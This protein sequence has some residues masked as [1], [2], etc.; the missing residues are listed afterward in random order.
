MFQYYVAIS[1]SDVS[2]S[3]IRV[4]IHRSLELFYRFLD[5]F[6]GSLVPIITTFQ[7]EPVSLCVISVPAG[8]LLLLFTC[9]TQ[10]KLI[11]Y[12]SR[13]VLLDSEYIGNLAVI[14]F[15]PKLR[16]RPG[17]NQIHLNVQRVSHQAHS[18][19]QYRAHIQIA[20][21]GL[22]VNFFSLVAEGST[23]RDDA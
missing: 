8:H 2:E 17:I 16:A 4:F 6:R 21:D 20:P 3:I 23:A 12:F 14:L 15:T 1:E 11:C 7:I 19:H 9:Q 22:R 13:N 5:S 18:T 10:P